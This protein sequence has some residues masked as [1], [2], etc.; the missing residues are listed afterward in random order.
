[1]I[2]DPN[3]NLEKLANLY[4]LADDGERIPLLK[5]LPFL[6]QSP[7]DLIDGPLKAKL[8]QA[9][10]MAFQELQARNE[11]FA[12][13]DGSEVSGSINEIVAQIDLQSLKLIHFPQKFEEKIDFYR[14][15]ATF[16]TM[17]GS[18]K[19]A[20]VAGRTIGNSIYIRGLD[21]SGGLL[22]DQA[23]YGR[24]E[25]GIMVK[26]RPDFYISL[27]TP[28]LDL[29]IE[30]EGVHMHQKIRMQITALVIGSKVAERI[31]KPYRRFNDSAPWDYQT[32]SP[33]RL[34]DLSLPEHRVVR[35]IRE[36]LYV[37]DKM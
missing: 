11:F 5:Y 8:R 29:P 4:Y 23:T 25:A 2:D 6:I 16:I 18:K 28:D 20:F 34:V 3:I 26:T 15:Y 24:N 31:G 12:V 33:A 19:R 32:M 35:Q 14:K 22:A 1:M 37:T 30:R 13:M 27:W 10:S 9:E 17:Y 36:A 21:R 7:K